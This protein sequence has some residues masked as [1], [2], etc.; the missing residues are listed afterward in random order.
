MEK[1]ENR[2]IALWDNLKF[3]LI[4]L[5]VIGHFSAKT[6]KW[7]FGGIYLFIYSSFK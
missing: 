7:P 1:T 4:L 6:G 2:R 3:L 5:V